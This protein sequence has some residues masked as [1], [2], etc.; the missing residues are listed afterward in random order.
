MRM[1]VSAVASAAVVL[2]TVAS[3]GMAVPGQAATAAPQYK[4]VLGPMNQGEYVGINDNGDIIGIGSDPAA[5]GRE[6]G[7]LI[8]AGTTTPVYLG[9]PGDETDQH[10]DTTPRS[11]ND[12][13]VIVGNYG[14]TVVFTGGEETIPRPATWPGTAIGSDLGVEPAGEAD[15]FG[16]ND[17]GQIVGKQAGSAFTPWLL[18]GTTVTNLP[19]P[20]G[21]VLTEALAI[22]DSG[23]AVGDFQ[24]ANGNLVATEW[25]GG[26]VSSLGTLNGGTWSEALAINDSGVAVGAATKRGSP[27]NLDSAVMFSNGKALDLN[28]PGTGQGPTQANA[29]NSSGVIVGE[30]GIDPDIVPVGDGFVYQNGH[31]ADL[32][33]LIAP[34]PNV[35][36]ASAAGIN[37]AGDIVGIAAITL[38]DG[39]QESAGYELVPIP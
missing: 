22:N 33:T 2:A 13:G 21:A 37:N 6:V 9:A 32:N 16:I 27:A 20:A 18:Q 14:K 35:R 10:T 36:L 34:T 3:V 7:F 8:K 39:T 29:I 15:A 19:V 1:R 11:I 28:A 26:K 25:S 23:V 12:Q 24:R 5:F 4:L 30:D 17:N 31:A 38:P